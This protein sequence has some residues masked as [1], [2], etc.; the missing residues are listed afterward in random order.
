M[1]AKEAI[2]QFLP[3]VKTYDQI[4]GRNLTIPVDK[5]VKFMED[6]AQIKVREISMHQNRQPCIL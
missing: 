3:H 1:N 4:E 6:Y 5:V 2:V